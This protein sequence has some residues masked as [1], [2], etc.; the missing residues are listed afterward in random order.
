MTAQQS[1]LIRLLA[2]RAFVIGVSTRGSPCS[3]DRK[4]WLVRAVMSR[5][6]PRRIRPSRRGT[7]VRRIS[8]SRMGSANPTEAASD[9]PTSFFFA[10]SCGGSKRKDWASMSHPICSLFG[11]L[12]LATLIGTPAAHAVCTSPKNIC[13]HIDDCL[14]QTSP[15]DNKNAERIREGVRTRD[16]KV[17]LAGAEACARDLGRKK[18]WDAWTRG[19]ADVEYVAIAKVEMEIGKAYCDRYSR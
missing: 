9:G 18:Q 13:K 16:G 7:T 19:C 14:Q 8:Q 11:S 5:D 1:R 4:S 3:P 6:I 2:R 15:P 17:V 10:K 12:V